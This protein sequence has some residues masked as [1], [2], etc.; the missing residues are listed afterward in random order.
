MI[1]KSRWYDAV[2]ISMN[3]MPI[4]AITETADSVFLSWADFEALA[5]MVTGAHDLSAAVVELAACPARRPPAGPARRRRRPAG[6]ALA[7][8]VVRR[9]GGA[10]HAPGAPP[11]ASRPCASTAPI[12]LKFSRMASMRAVDCARR[13]HS[14]HS[15]ITTRRPAED[16]DSIDRRRAVDVDPPEALDPAAAFAMG[17]WATAKHLAQP[18]RP[19]RRR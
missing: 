7:R 18:G 3:S 11:S 10:G 17:Q 14:E 16:L 2:G 1:Q 9:G 8:P 15:M 13:R 19:P 6:S 4:T 12:R 5:E